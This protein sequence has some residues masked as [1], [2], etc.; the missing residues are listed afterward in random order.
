M[1]LYK[2]ATWA[3][4][5]LT[6]ANPWMQVRICKRA[7]GW[8]WAEIFTP[9]GKCMA[10]LDH[11]GELLLRDQ[12]IPMRLEA[13]SFEHAQTSEGES[14]SF[15]VKSLIVKDKLR[16]TSFDPWL[17]YPIEKHSMTGVTTL[18]LAPD[19]PVLRI[20]MRF[21]SHGIQWARYVRGPWL[22][23]GEGS[24]AAARTDAIFPGIEWLEGDEW[25]SG[26]DWFKDPW[27]KR[28]VPHP[29]KV[30]IP[31]MTLSHEGDAVTLSWEPRQQVSGWFN[32]R[33]SLPQPVFASPNFID[34][35][36]NH[37]M[38]LMIPDAEIEAFENQTE[39]EPALQLHMEQRINFDAEITL[40]RGT[41]LEAITDWV[42]RKGMPVVPAPRWPFPEAL[43]RIAAAY[44]S[45]LW[46][47]GR[48]FGTEQAPGHFNAS[49][50]PFPGGFS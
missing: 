9:E 17:N 21:I 1:P 18:T 7:T 32:Y 34:R 20:S 5:E 33:R 44:N 28:F 23:A 39:R 15:P 35:A 47:E 22:K 8:G 6:L 29:N 11:F 4:E 38:G 26:K 12:E 27:A 19:A 42:A 49:V 37:L 13:D 14:Y 41:S 46:H 31:L 10:I 43:E 36:N 25:S 2:R 40:S 45:H 16:N 3:N 48:G 30:A 50:P 24:Y